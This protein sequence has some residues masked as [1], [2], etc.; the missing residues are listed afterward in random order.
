[1]TEIV[2]TE[3]GMIETDQIV[4]ETELR[5]S[6]MVI[7]SMNRRTVTVEM[8]IRTWRPMVVVVSIKVGFGLHHD[9]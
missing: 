8:M 2:A 6:V 1:M 3:T 4:L 9:E 7:A 5:R